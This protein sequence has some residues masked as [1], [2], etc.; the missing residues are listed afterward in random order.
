MVLV[1]IERGKRLLRVDG[2]VVELARVLAR[3][4]GGRRGDNGVQVEPVSSS[5]ALTVTRGGVRGHAAQAVHIVNEV[6]ADDAVAFVVVDARDE[7]VIRVRVHLTTL[8]VVLA[9]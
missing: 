5:R 1:A 2:V 9:A 7:S 6:V 8:V 4:D 3:P